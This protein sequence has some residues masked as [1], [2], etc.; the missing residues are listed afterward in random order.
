[1]LTIFYDGHCP[2]CSTEIKELKQQ[3][4]N[5]LIKIVNIR[6]NDCATLYPSINFNDST[7][8]NQIHSKHQD[9][10]LPEQSATHTAWTL[11]EKGLIGMTLKH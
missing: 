2:L 1:M 3:D 8:S 11:V 7:T 10:L 4:K 6:D 5:H 9:K